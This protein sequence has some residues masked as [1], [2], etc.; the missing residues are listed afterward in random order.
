MRIT[1]SSKA[2]IRLEDGVK[3]PD[4][5]LY[6]TN[7]K[8]SP[9]VARYPS[10]V[11][12]V[13]YSEN[14]RKLAMDAARHICMSRFNI[15]LVI[16]IDIIHK[17]NELTNVDMAFWEMRDVISAKEFDGETNKLTRLD[18]YKDDDECVPPPA[19]AYFAVL[20]NPVTKQLEKYIA[21]TTS[22][23]TVST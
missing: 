13:G 7:H 5:S 1:D 11:F 22:T 6:E 15:Q 17:N 2:D 12:E 19:N 14:S 21:G 18:E 4:G 20:E 9:S 16:A 3:S 8:L 23:W 10:V